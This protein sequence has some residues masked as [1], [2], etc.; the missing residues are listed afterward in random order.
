M[1]VMC[2]LFDS[3]EISQ[4]TIVIKAPLFLKSQSAVMI[5]IKL[6]YNAIKSLILQFVASATFFQI[7][8]LFPN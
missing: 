5:D 8:L 4:L 7:R 3:E 1:F 6:N 2:R